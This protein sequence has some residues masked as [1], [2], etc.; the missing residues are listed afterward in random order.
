[1][2]T[3]LNI[4]LIHH[5][6]L[7]MRKNKLFNLDLIVSGFLIRLSIWGKREHIPILIIPGGYNK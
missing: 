3:T 4:K 6:S 5:R 1:M 7:C 2:L